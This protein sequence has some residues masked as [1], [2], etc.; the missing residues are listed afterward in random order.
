[1]GAE[2]ILLVE[3]S[4]FFGSLLRNR[5]RDR[6]NLE[7]RWVGTMAEALA[8]LD[9]G[10]PPF[11]LA[12]LDLNLPDAPDGEIVDVALERGVP[13]IIMTGLLSDAMRDQMWSRRVV[14]YVIK[15]GPHAIEYV[16]ALV[17]RI[18]HNERVE[19]LVVDDSV[20]ARSHI[21]SLLA[22]HRYKVLE[23]PDGATALA[24]LEDH[25]DVCL[26]L[27]D[28]HMPDMDGAKLTLHARALRQRDELAI[29]G[30]STY[31]TA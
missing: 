8:A 30:V 1:M 18:L 15:D 7:V 21:R 16:V 3:D 6:L 5:L 19:V 31:G 14:D 25:P 12:L 23:A 4:R 24:M 13:P 29:I 11:T 10:G 20:V 27:A 9:A 28:Y 22:V 26:M 2:R 17:R